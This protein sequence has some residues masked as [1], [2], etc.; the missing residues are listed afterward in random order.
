MY[1]TLIRISLSNNR[2]FTLKVHAFWPV[3]IACAIA[4]HIFG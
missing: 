2:V 1:L 4:W 3:L